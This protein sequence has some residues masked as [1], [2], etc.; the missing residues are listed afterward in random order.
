MSGVRKEN[1]LSFSNVACCLVFTVFDFGGNVKEFSVQVQNVKDI[2]TALRFYQAGDWQQL[3]PEYGEYC[4]TNCKDIAE[5][6][7]VGLKVFA[8]DKMGNRLELTIG[9]TGCYS[10]VELNLA[11]IAEENARKLKA[12]RE[13]L[14]R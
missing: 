3:F 6:L 9:S 13:I 11:K 12:I 5:V 2:E 7:F 10:E 1:T 8:A 4:G 14:E